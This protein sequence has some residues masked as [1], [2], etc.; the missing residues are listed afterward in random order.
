MQLLWIIS[1]PIKN[2]VLKFQYSVIFL[3][4]AKMLSNKSQIIN[5]V[6]RKDLDSYIVDNRFLGISN[7]LLK[8][9]KFHIY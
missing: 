6:D 5:I 8:I 2:S 1:D 3:F 7:G 4:N 9:P